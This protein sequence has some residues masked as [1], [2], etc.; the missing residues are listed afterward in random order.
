MTS[1][2]ILEMFGNLKVDLLDIFSVHFVFGAIVGIKNRA[3]LTD[4]CLFC[5]INAK[6][7][8]IEEPQPQ[9]PLKEGI[10]IDILILFYF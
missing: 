2:I 1:V 7:S 6:S 3:L 4:K 5:Y 8:P 10:T 9:F